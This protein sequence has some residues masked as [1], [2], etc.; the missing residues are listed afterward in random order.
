MPF[1][2]QKLASIYFGIGRM[3]LIA[4]HIPNDMGQHHVIQI[5]FSAEHDFAIRTNESDWKK[6]KLVILDS[7]LPHQLKDLTGH[8]VSIAIIPE[9][10]R[11]KTIRKNILKGEKIVFPEIDMTNFHESFMNCMNEEYNCQK[12]FSLFDECIDFLTGTTGFTGPIDQRILEVIEI[13][14]QNIQR[15]FSAARLA[16]TIHLSEDRFLHLF[17]E[18]MGLP[19]RQFIL[20]QR[21][22]F[23]TKYFMDGKSLTEAA[24]DAGFSDS[25]HFTRTFIAMNGNKPSDIAKFKNLFRV[26][27]CFPEK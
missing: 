24:I 6:T 12:A 27:I 25:A 15:S 20:Y 7:N 21:I 3:L 4:P 17:K 9:N 19:L 2:Q 22:I 11:G 14:H 5:T 8:Q 16:E 10:S 26:F 23:A 1:T 18:Q 13:I